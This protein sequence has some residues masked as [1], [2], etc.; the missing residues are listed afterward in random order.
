MRLGVS[1]YPAELNFFLSEEIVDVA[2]RVEDT[3]HFD[4]VRVGQIEEEIGF[5]VFHSRQA[6]STAER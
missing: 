2:G 6:A 3:Y 4:A 5:E 1:T